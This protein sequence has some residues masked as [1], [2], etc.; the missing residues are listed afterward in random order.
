ML[1]HL[2]VRRPEPPLEPGRA[3]GVSGGFAFVPEF[4]PLLGE[5]LAGVALSLWLLRAIASALYGVSPADPLT[6]AAAVAAVVICTL[7]GAAVPAWR[8]SAADPMA[9]LRKA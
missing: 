9:L 6:I 7:A 8:A 5:D 4:A 2:F 1:L 3:L